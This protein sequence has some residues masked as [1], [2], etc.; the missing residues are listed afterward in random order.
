[1]PEPKDHYENV[2]G[3]NWLMRKIPGLGGYFERDDRRDADHKLR[4]WL[5]DR[6]QRSK[7]GIDGLSR[8][9]VDK[10]QLEALPLCDRLRAKLDKL[11]GRI[12]SAGRGY[13]S[14]FDVHQIDQTVL[15]RVY[16]HDVQLTDSVDQ[17]AGAIEQL[18]HGTSNP[19]AE[20]NRLISEI[21]GLD[22]KWNTRE[23]ILRGLK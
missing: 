23:E 12:Q 13:S 3:L 20:I 19:E 10:V 6:L 17:L 1:M 15:E 8:S 5:A 9:L 11:I 7:S 22:Q 21:D 18:S 14:F 4:S 16:E 2:G